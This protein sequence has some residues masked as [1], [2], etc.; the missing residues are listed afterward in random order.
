MQR[1]GEIVA[2]SADPLLKMAKHFAAC[3][4]PT[5]EEL[6]KRMEDNAASSD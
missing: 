3:P 4:S 6:P 2:E 1:A 5:I